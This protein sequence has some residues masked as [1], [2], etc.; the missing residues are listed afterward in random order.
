MK[1][2]SCVVIGP[3]VAYGWAAGPRERA[4]G[5]RLQQGGWELAVYTG[6]P[7]AARGILAL[8]DSPGNRNRAVQIGAFQATCRERVMTACSIK[9]GQT[10]WRP[11]GFA[12]SAARPA[13]QEV[14]WHRGFDEVV[15][16]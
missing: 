10:G 16:D 12:E 1:T 13:L 3:R 6:I 4:G 11:A 9:V 14:Q 2:A 8:R 15:S 7:S 5:I